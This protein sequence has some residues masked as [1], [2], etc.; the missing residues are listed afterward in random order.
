MRWRALHDWRLLAGALLLMTF[1]A[2][3]AAEEPA[4][5]AQPG[6]T[7]ATAEAPATAAPAA[8]P[9][10]TAAKPPEAPTYSRSGADTCLNCHSGPEVLGV[11]RTKH[12]QPKDPHSPFGHGQLQ[13]EACHG[14]GGAHTKRVPRGEARPPMIRFGK[15]SPTPVDVQNG[16][17][18]G[19]HQAD[20]KLS[21]HGGAHEEND[22]PCAA[23]H[24]SH[25][26]TD[27][28]LKTV[29]QPD[30]CGSCHI[31]ERMSHNK[32]YA[33]PLRYGQLGCT[34]CHAPHKGSSEMQL[35][36][37]NVNLTCYTCHAE[38]RGPFVWEHAPVTEDC[39]ICHAP[40]G[41]NQ[42]AMLTQRAPL[43]C[44]SCH[45]QVGHPSIPQGSGGLPGG[46]PSAY[47]L[48]GSCTNCHSQIH[49]SNHPSGTAFTR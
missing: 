20:M 14:P 29:S 33:H 16:A 19:C 8:A 25:T 28:V 13:C 27:A 37:E 4:K 32:A 12:G 3:Q 31:T 39:T 30:V 44:Q 48:N 10:E 36:R 34:A 17:C 42:P 21:W 43:L 7:S 6:A 2:L 40:H 47:L 24:R 23:C 1:A 45:S 18:L 38:K 35:N 5:S 15:N 49:G 22:V 41:S 9:A 46:I 26:E 11:F